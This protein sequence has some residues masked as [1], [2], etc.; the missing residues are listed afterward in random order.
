VEE[1]LFS[2]RNCPHCGG[3]R[4]LVRS[5]AGGFV[6]QNCKNNCDERRGGKP[7]L[8]SIDELPV[9]LCADCGTE[10]GTC[11]VDKNY[12]YRCGRCGTILTVAD[13]IPPWE[14]YFNE[15]GVAIPGWDFERLT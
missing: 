9:R 12:A 14:K 7:S 13:L 15:D 11:Y 10:M 3:R 8:V 1:L 6:T 2:R 5:R 4:I